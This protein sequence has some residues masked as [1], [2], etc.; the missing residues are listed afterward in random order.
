MDESSQTSTPEDTKLLSLLE[1]VTQ[2]AALPSED[3]SKLLI[4]RSRVI[5][6]RYVDYL[7]LLDIK[8]LPHTSFKDSQLWCLILGFHQ[9]P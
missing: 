6:A 8:L 9:C 4:L 3:S 7:S 1:S 2:A 5:T